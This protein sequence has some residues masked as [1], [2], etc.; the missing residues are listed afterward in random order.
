MVLIEY[1]RLYESTALDL[2]YTRFRLYQE[3]D[4]VF[5]HK[6]KSIGVL[7]AYNIFTMVIQNKTQR[8][9]AKRREVI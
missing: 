6:W 1:K 4:R 2:W 3:V 9:N 5:I 7:N 8:K